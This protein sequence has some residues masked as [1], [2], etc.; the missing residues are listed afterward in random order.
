MTID[1]SARPLGNET[2]DV[3]V[4][5]LIGLGRHIDRVAG[6]AGE[7]KWILVCVLA[8]DFRLQCRPGAFRL[9]ALRSRC[10]ACRARAGMRG[11]CILGVCVIGTAR[12][13]V[14]RRPR[15]KPMCRLALILRLSTQDPGLWGEIRRF[16]TGERL[17]CRLDVGIDVS[18][19][20]RRRVK[21]SIIAWNERLQEMRR[22][23]FGCSGG[24]KTKGFGLLIELFAFSLG[25]RAQP[26]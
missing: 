8:A 5:H 3:G 25:Y 23:V 20:V 26:P 18:A 24:G 2:L 4:S 12:E 7:L 9:G 21:A 10:I 6:L 16:K 15:G 11:P 14:R 17:L 22:D 19:Y 1:K 13:I